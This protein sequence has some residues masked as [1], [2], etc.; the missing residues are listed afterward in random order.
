MF[1]LEEL[2]KDQKSSCGSAPNVPSADCAA[3]MIGEAITSNT[4]RIFISVDMYNTKMNTFR[5]HS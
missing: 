4:F 2:Q 1:K 3:I 5:D